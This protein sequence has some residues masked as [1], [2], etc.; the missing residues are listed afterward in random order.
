MRILALNYLLDGAR[1]KVLNACVNKEECKTME[2]TRDRDQ[3][4][5]STAGDR[6]RVVTPA[7]NPVYTTGGVLFL[8][9]DLADAE[10]V[11]RY[12]SQ[13]RRPRRGTHRLKSM[14]GKY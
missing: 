2:T 14:F 10:N 1:I 7:G 3:H 8:T 13:R 5:V 9:D 6:Y 11:A 12:L 4:R